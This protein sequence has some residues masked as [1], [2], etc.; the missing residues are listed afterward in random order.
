MTPNLGAIRLSA[1]VNLQIQPLKGIFLPGHHNFPVSF[2]F[3][4]PVML[5]ISNSKPTTRYGA[6]SSY[7]LY[8]PSGP[9]PFP[10]PLFLFSLPLS[11][12]LGHSACSP[13]PRH[14]LSSTPT[15]QHLLPDAALLRVPN[16]AGSVGSGAAEEVRPAA[17]CGEAG[18]GGPYAGA[19]PGPYVGEPRVRFRW[20]WSRRS[21][22]RRHRAGRARGRRMVVTRAGAEDGGGGQSAL[23]SSAA[24]RFGVPTAMSSLSVGRRGAPR[25]HG[26]SGGAWRA[27]KAVAAAAPARR[28]FAASTSAGK[29]GRI[30]RRPHPWRL[31]GRLLPLLQAQHGVAVSALS[32]L[33]PADNVEEPSRY[34]PHTT[35]GFPGRS[36]S[37]R[38]ALDFQSFRP[39]GSVAF[40]LQVAGAGENTG[41]VTSRSF[42]RPYPAPSADSLTTDGH[43]LW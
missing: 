19:S 25:R 18:D 41:K 7:F 40:G 24:T 15:A 12:F 42:S 10:F 37:T 5:Y 6:H 2:S 14:L 36:S 26:G 4:A 20:R 13:S 30:H 1:L 11:P 32:L 27:W 16:R 38:R 34:G 9:P 17:Q 39:N 29:Q 35:S 23:L 8:P 21:I 22:R 43:A 3:S 28:I 33:L 31:G